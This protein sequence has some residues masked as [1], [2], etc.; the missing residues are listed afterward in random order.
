M[1]VVSAK[2]VSC[3]AKATAP[4]AEPFVYLVDHN[5][6]DGSDGLIEQLGLTPPQ[7]L[8]VACLRQAVTSNHGVIASAPS[9]IGGLGT[10]R[11][12][13]GDRRRLS[14]WWDPSCSA[15]G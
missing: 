3:W 9:D 1:E 7:R 14:N 5:H 12:E 6:D 4:L 13:P 2:G 8:V 10:K 15:I 11:F